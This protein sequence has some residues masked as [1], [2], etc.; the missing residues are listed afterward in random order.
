MSLPHAMSL[1]Q[2]LPHIQSFFP[3]STQSSISQYSSHTTNYAPHLLCV[4]HPLHILHPLPL[5]T[6]CAE[7][8]L[9]PLT[10]HQLVSH[11][12]IASH[13]HLTRRLPCF[14]CF[15]K[16]THKSIQLFFLVSHYSAIL[17]ANK[18]GLSQTCHNFHSEVP[19]IS[20]VPL[21]SPFVPHHPYAHS[22][23]TEI[24]HHPAQSNAQNIEHQLSSLRYLTHALAIEIVIFPA[25]NIGF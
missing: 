7:K 15:T 13:I 2:S 19:S 5:V 21:P 24:P 3:I 17:S 12:V 22:T 16:L 20:Q 14:T 4:S 9:L 8:N 25:R 6:P 18:A 1:T 11:P 23:T 10:V